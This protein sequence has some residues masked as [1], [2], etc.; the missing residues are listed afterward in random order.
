MYWNYEPLFTAMSGPGEVC[1]HGGEGRGGEGRGG[2]AE[3]LLLTNLLMKMHSYTAH[4]TRLSSSCI[5][6][7][8]LT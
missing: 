2:E 6:E 7:V 4:G 5:T 1:L 3:V 8:I